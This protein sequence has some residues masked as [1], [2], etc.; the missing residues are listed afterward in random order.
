VDETAFPPRGPQPTEPSAA[1]TFAAACRAHEAGH[2]QQ[3]EHLYCQVVQA[4][5]EHAQAWYWLGAACHELGKPQE[6]HLSLEHALRHQPRHAPALNLLGVVLAHQGRLEEA[7]DYFCQGLQLQPHWPEAIGNLHRACQQL[8]QQPGAVAALERAV[9]LRPEDGVLHYWLGLALTGHNRPEEAVAHLRRAAHFYPNLAEVHGNLGVAC[10]LHNRLEE[11][12]ACFDQVL[13]LRPDSA[14]A[15]Y[16]LGVVRFKQQR[17]EEAIALFR[18]TLRAR[19]TYA[20]AHGYLGLALVYQDR[21]DEG[22]ACL[23]QALALNPNLAEAYGYQGYALAAAG[24]FADALASFERALQLKPDNADTH[25][26]RALVWLL[27]GDWQR[28]LPEYEWRWQTG[29]FAD[30]PF[31]QPLWDGSSLAG[32]TILLYAEQGLGDT[33]QFI[34]YAPLVR[35][36]G[37]TVVVSC[38]DTLVPLLSRC[39]GIDQL[40]PASAAVPPCDV[41]APL[42]SLPWLLGTT[43]ATIPNRVPYLF[44]DPSL[45]E[46]WRLQLPDGPAFKIGIAWQGNPGHRKDKVRSIPLTAFAPLAGI[47]G[48][49]LYSLQKGPGTEQLPEFAARFPVIDLGSRLGEQAGAFTDTAAAL[50]RL[51]LLVASDTAIVH[52]A[53]GL[54]VPVFMPVS[55]V[56]DWR[57][58]LDRDDTPW[59]P[60][61]RLF[62]QT[63]R[64]NWGSVFAGLTAAVA[65]RCAGRVP[66]G[67]VG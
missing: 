57:W 39:R 8:S 11:A 21:L 1:D 64:G 4:Q 29:R 32:R 31:R 33:L 6:A 67:V 49:Q 25:F 38:P 40:V 13:R 36:R 9:R 44:A 53:G 66:G 5:P 51:D 27:L 45:A 20:E 56:P 65:Q 3:A 16:N 58:L 50:L 12:A 2:L 60:T 55:L 7:V 54:G 61:V 10:L 14:E 47:P 46:H 52:L 28:G 63:E 59:Y 23:G 35:E 24:R 15:L 30:V 17:R 43:P 19:P 37:G 48:V 22:L 41:R 26:E 62:R 34:R 42:L 18:Q